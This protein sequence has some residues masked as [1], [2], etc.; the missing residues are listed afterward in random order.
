MCVEGSRDVF[1]K[2]LKY[3]ETRTAGGARYVFIAPS[4]RIFLFLNNILCKRKVT[5]VNTRN[6]YRQMNFEESECLTVLVIYYFRLQIQF[7]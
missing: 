2:F 3:K 5:L 7:I 6:Y 4:Y 1:S